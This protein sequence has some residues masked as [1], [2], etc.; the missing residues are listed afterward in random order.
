MK[1]GTGV[2]S[3]AMSAPKHVVC[4]ACHL[5][6]EQPTKNT[7]LGFPSFVCE[8]C[9]VK[10]ELPLSTIYVG[11]YAL[12]LFVCFVAVVTRGGAGCFGIIGLAAIPSLILHARAKQKLA[13]ALANEKG[14]GERIADTFR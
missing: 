12:A 4:L 9:G 5:G 2:C 6:Q 8:A 13:V 3:A 11:I 14:R 10:S 7:F 1:L